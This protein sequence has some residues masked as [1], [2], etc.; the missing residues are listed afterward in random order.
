MKSTPRI[1]HAVDEHLLNTGVNP[2]MS[3]ISVINLSYSMF[4]HLAVVDL[5][6]PRGPLLPT[7]PFPL[8]HHARIRKEENDLFNDAFNTFYLPLYGV[9]RMVK[10]HSDRK[11]GNLL[12]Y[13]F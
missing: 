9:R 7:S 5:G 10:D 8:S 3:G 13:S 12:G 11:R 4:F 6:G 1:K 2:L